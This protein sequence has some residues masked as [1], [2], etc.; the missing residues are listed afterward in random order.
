MA[1]MT[2]SNQTHC[3]EAL[4]M[5]PVKWSQLPEDLLICALARVPVIHFQRLRSV[6][7]RWNELALEKQFSQLRASTFCDA[8]AGFALFQTSGHGSQL[9][10]L[11]MAAPNTWRTISFD[12]THISRCIKF[13]ATSRGILLLWSSGDNHNSPTVQGS[14]YVCN[15]IIETWRKLPRPSHLVDEPF[16][17]AIDVNEFTGDFVVVIAE[18]ELRQGA[19]TEVFNSKV[20]F[21][22]KATA[23]SRSGRRKRVA[24]TLITPW[25][26]GFVPVYCT[27]VFSKGAFYHLTWDPE[28]MLSVFLVAEEEWRCVKGRGA[29]PPEGEPWGVVETAGRVL[30]VE[31]TNLKANEEDAYLHTW[32]LEPEKLAW[33][34]RKRI[35]SPANKERRLRAWR[36]FAVGDGLVCVTFMKAAGTVITFH[37]QGD[38]EE[39]LI[40]DLGNERWVGMPDL[41]GTP[42]GSTACLFSFKASLV[43]PPSPLHTDAMPSSPP[44]TH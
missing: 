24:A 22:K 20:G 4:W 12:F 9:R 27:P 34:K 19:C 35:P 38:P 18:S 36:R 31:M 17:S 6:C 28:D 33:G 10:Y 41:P 8:S 40:Y 37:N 44:Q 11:D 42:P 23:I 29:I 39:G 7:R 25:S 43:C 5:D 32:E 26:F 15:P 21:W 30:V 1:T 3:L 14:L 2:T 13:L 16:Y